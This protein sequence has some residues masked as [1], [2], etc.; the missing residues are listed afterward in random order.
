MM[1]RDILFLIQVRY[2]PMVLNV[3]VYQLFPV[4]FSLISFLIQDMRILT[5]Y[6]CSFSVSGLCSGT[7]C[8]L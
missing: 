4:K 8:H 1:I 7:W 3:G 5:M 2:H 6:C